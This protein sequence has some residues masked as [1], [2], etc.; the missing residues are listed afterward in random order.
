MDDLE[1]ELIEDALFV[2]E[3]SVS[4]LVTVVE[5]SDALSNEWIFGNTE[6]NEEFYSSLREKGLEVTSKERVQ[7][8][9]LSLSE[10][11]IAFQAVAY[12]L[13]SIN[14]QVFD[15]WE[16]IETDYNASI[17]ASTTKAIFTTSKNQAFHNKLQDNRLHL[18][19]VLEFLM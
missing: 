2:V 7:N 14:E 4:L 6:I 10:G 16:I 3:Q 1:N 5:F 13:D 8:L 18:I 15:S 9:E 11:F 17:H 12:T 19:I